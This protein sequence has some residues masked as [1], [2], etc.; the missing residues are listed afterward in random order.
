[1]KKTVCA[2]LLLLLL[3]ISS[4][5][6]EPGQPLNESSVDVESLEM[7]S[8]QIGFSVTLPED[9]RNTSFFIINDVI[10]QVTFAYE[11]IAY[12]F[13]ASKIYSGQSLY[14]MY[15]NFSSETTF[16]LTD[17]TEAVN[18]VFKDGANLVTWFDA[19]VY[20]SLYCTKNISE[21]TFITICDSL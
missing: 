18:S 8:N 5:A 10:A 1:M 7:L 3:L 21:N 17:N 4:C 19:G 20:K 15:D 14:G 11:G 12:T 13:R 2:F 6:P 16:T 9:A